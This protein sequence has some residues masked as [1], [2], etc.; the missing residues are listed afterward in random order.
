MTSINSHN[1]CLVCKNSNL[2]KLDY[3]NEPYYGD[4]VVNFSKL[5]IIY[6]QNCGFGWSTPEIQIE[7]LNKFY[8]DIYRS[9]G[10]T[11][12]INFSRLYRPK[13]S[14]CTAAIEHFSL[15]RLFT[16]VNSGDSL[17]DIGPGPGWHFQA[18]QSLLENPKL[19]ALEYNLGAS[20][21]Y[22]QLY[23]ANSFTNIE[24]LKANVKHKMKFIV[25]SHSLEHFK[26][27][28]LIEFL[29]D[30]KTILM[31]DGVFIIEVP[32]VDMR[33]H[34]KCRGGDSPHLLFFSK[35]SL[36]SVLVSCGYEVKFID[37]TGPLYE[38]EDNQKLSPK[39]T[40]NLTSLIRALYKIIFPLWF[41]SSEFKKSLK[42][43]IIYFNSSSSKIKLSQLKTNYRGNRVALRVVA[44]KNQNI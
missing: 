25:A 8:S 4:E 42:A 7:L 39:L 12:F 26:Y 11:H 40:N 3:I 9:K 20:E 6:C 30:I 41:R 38:A 27:N 2:A 32:H 37:S 16:T 5:N 36:K 34:S 19:Y 29:T 14:Q 10:Q 31:D 1:Y 13:F 23:G 28:D 24:D 33:I 21:A 18:A 43:L 15:A 44:K 35:K 22:K 17:L